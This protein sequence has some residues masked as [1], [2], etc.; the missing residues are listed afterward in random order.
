MPT[1]MLIVAP[2]PEPDSMYQSPLSATGS[3]PADSHSCISFLWVPESSPRD[4]NSLPDLAMARNAAA[5]VPVL[6]TPAGS[7]AGPIKMKSLYITS[8]R[9]TPCPAATNSSSALRA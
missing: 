5:A 8:K 4:T 3:I 9:S 6:A 1:V 7:S 2:M